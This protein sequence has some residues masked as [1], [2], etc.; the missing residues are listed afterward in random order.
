MGNPADNFIYNSKSYSSTDLSGFDISLGD[1]K[2]NA[3]WSN[4]FSANSDKLE[5]VFVKERRKCHHYLYVSFG[6]AFPNVPGLKHPDDNSVRTD[7]WPFSTVTTWSMFNAVYPNGTEDGSYN[8]GLGF[9]PSSS[10]ISPYQIVNGNLT[11]G[12]SRPAY[13]YSIWTGTEKAISYIEGD[14]NNTVLPSNCEKVRFM[15]GKM[16]NCYWTSNAYTNP[17]Y[18]SD[19][20]Q[21]C[22][23][24]SATT[25][26][27]DKV[28]GQTKVLNLNDMGKVNGDPLF[29]LA[30]GEWGIHSNINGVFANNCQYHSNGLP[31]LHT[32][33]V[34]FSNTSVDMSSPDWYH[35]IDSYTVYIYKKN[36]YTISYNANGGLG[37]MEDTVIY[38]GDSGVLSP[39]A[40]TREG[41]YFLNWK[42][43]NGNTW[44]DSSTI[45]PT[46]NLTM[47]AQWIPINYDVIIHPNSPTGATSDV[48]PIK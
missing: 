42:D 37:N 30:F 21:R 36:V 18:G 5:F 15:D 48:R 29:S 24:P 35:Y 22:S 33:G 25:T 12:Y 4:L 8:P 16:V 11:D 9:M 46:E 2:S 10:Y 20:Y 32:G 39:N 1:Y 31:H 7:M 40:F 28:T 14:I 27:V 45:T 38:I 26:L 17:T 44:E 43:Q 19:R 47:Y 6:N 23:N 13:G 34:S 41:Y 3:F